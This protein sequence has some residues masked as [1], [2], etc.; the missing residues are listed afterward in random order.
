MRVGA[1][2]TGIGSKLITVMDT[3]QRIT[4]CQELKLLQAR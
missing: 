2:R 4:I 1:E 3:S